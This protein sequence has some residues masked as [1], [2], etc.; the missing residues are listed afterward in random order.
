MKVHTSL[1]TSPPFAKRGERY[2]KFATAFFFQLLF[3][4]KKIVKDHNT[5]K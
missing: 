4:L 5:K 2:V 3:K 1:Q